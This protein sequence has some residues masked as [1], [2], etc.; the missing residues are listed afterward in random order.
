MIKE[1]ILEHQEGRK[2]Y[3]K[4]NTLVN[5]TDSPFP[6]G[7]STLCLIIEA[8]IIKLCDVV[9]NKY[10]GNTYNFIT[11]EEGERSNGT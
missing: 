5:T 7:F 9:L 4:E 2:I 6:L 11:Q 1:G 8:K 3:S 10:A